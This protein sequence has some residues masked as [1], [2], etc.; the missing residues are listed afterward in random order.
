MP[1]PKGSYALTGILSGDVEPAADW[2]FRARRVH[3]RRPAASYDEG[4]TRTTTKVADGTRP[5]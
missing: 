2:Y 1:L 3:H 5:R 4:R